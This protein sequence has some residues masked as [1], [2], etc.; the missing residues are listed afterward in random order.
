V[1]QSSGI[2]LFG[3]QPVWVQ[4]TNFVAGSDQPHAGRLI[5]HSVFADG[6]CRARLGGG[7]AQVSGAVYQGFV[8]TLSQHRTGY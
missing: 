1:L 3:D 4:Q 2:V 8:A 5:V 6:A 7:I